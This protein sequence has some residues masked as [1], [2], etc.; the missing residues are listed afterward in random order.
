MNIEEL[1]ELWRQAIYDVLGNQIDSAKLNILARQTY[2][3]IRRI[4]IYDTYKI[5]A[6]DAVANQMS[7][8][9]TSNPFVLAQRKDLS[10]QERVWVVYLATY[11]GKSKN[12]GWDLFKRASF[13]PDQS[14]IKFEQIKDDI[15]SY[16][17]YLS[18]IDFFQGCTFSNH[19]KYTAKE[20]N[21]SKGL[22]RSID[23]FVKNIQIY[24]PEVEMDFHD[25]FLLSIKIPNFGRL[26]GFDFTSSLAKLD[27]N[28]KEPTS[29]YADHSTGPLQALGLLLKLTGNNTAIVYQRELGSDLMSWFLTNSTIFMVGQVLEDAICNWQKNTTRYIR[30]VG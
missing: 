7:F 15:D 13:K 12:S 28:V 17:K 1:E 16:F 18:S 9:H 29:M 14:I 19:R 21:G 10:F 4:R 27:L 25:M 20:L 3:S 6:N 11:F 2:D 5:K 24:C 26:A 8:S 22:F 23:Y 30:Y